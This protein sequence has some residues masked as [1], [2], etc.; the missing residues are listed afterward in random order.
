MDLQRV[1]YQ[2]R[3]VIARARMAEGLEYDCWLTTREL[4]VGWGD[5]TRGAWRGTRRAGVGLIDLLQPVHAKLDQVLGVL[6]GE[7]ATTHSQRMSFRDVH[8]LTASSFVPGDPPTRIILP[9]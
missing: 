4:D 5:R 7:C 3:D 8:A 1:V 2:T 9:A 6:G